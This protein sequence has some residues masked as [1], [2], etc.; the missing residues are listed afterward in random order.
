MNYGIQPRRVY[1]GATLMELILV[2]ILAG[3]ISVFVAPRLNQAPIAEGGF[4]SELLV[5]AR[6]A[7]SVAIA[8]GCEIQLNTTSS[9]YALTQRSG[10]VTGPFSVNVLNP[11]S[12]KAFSGS[13]PSGVSLNTV[14]VIFDAIGRSTSGQVEITVAGSQSRTIRIEGE[15]GFA[16]EV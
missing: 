15:T 16:H 8:S 4:F 2:L 7:R 11:G 9:T 14:S 10:C 12:G 3:I 13:P 5:A 1:A 6:Y